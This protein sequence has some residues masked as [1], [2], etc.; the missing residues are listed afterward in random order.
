MAHGK[1]VYLHHGRIVISENLIGGGKYD[2]E[3]Y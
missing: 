2:G 3:W 1:G